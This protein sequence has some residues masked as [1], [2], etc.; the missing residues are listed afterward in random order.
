MSESSPLLRTAQRQQ[1]Q[2]RGN[3]YWHPTKPKEKVHC[4]AVNPRGEAGP[5]Q[6]AACWF[7]A[8]EDAQLVYERMVGCPQLERHTL[9]RFELFVPCGSSVPAIDL[10]ALS[11]TNWGTYRPLVSRA[12]RT[13]GE[14]PAAS[15]ALPSRLLMLA[16]SVL[17]EAVAC[18]ARDANS[19]LA[20]AG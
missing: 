17:P 18:V 15:S 20:V 2:M 16:H 10:L 3:S 4:I 8:S 13:Q 7:R 6:G 19:C 11:A 1:R 5:G 12:A 14:L 9:E